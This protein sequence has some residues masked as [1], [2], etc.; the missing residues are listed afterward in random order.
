MGP[1]N[2]NSGTALQGKYTRMALMR[3]Y[4]SARIFVML[5]VVFSVL[6]IAFLCFGSDSA[7]LFG[8]MIPYFLVLSGLINT[9]MF[10]EEYY[11]EQYPDNYQN[12]Q[13]L[14]TS[15]FYVLLIMAIVI[16]VVYFL[17]WLLSKN[18]HVGYLITALVMI[19]V[20]TL[21]TIGLLLSSISVA[22]MLAVLF[23]AFLIFG[24]SG[25]VIAG[26]KLKKL[27]VE[28]ERAPFE[29]TVDNGGTSNEENGK[30]DDQNM[31]S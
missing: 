14:N 27:P 20:D 22:L 17:M 11:K 12:L 1:I 5:I 16:V 29:I 28:E 13:F 6:N 9:G 21:F 31:L 4:S 7:F 2:N 19:S 10:D 3:N 15:F 23:H 8:A 18:G 30:S 24:I 25:G 26:F